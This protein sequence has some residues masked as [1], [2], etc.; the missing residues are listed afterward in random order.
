MQIWT[1]YK[2]AK[3]P[4]RQTTQPSYP[5]IVNVTCK[6][7]KIN[8]FIQTFLSFRVPL[9]SAFQSRTASRSAASLSRLSL[10]FLC[11]VISAPLHWTLFMSHT[12][13]T[14]FFYFNVTVTAKSRET[15][16]ITLYI[17]QLE[18]QNFSIWSMSHYSTGSYVG[19]SLHVI[20]IALFER[21]FITLLI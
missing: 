6:R 3:Y 9:S 11:S 8:R 4:N 19:T 13:I 10:I 5:K 21:L 14:S 20:D 17:K 18:F 12:A 1:Y 2:D 16:R 7:L 15:I